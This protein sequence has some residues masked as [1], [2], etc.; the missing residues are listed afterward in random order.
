MTDDHRGGNFIF[1]DFPVGKS[2]TFRILTTCG[3]PRFR[4]R[5]LNENTFQDFDIAYAI[6]NNLPQSEDISSWE[7]DKNPDYRGSEISRRNISNQYE[8]VQ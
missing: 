5:I 3:Y 6:I 1:D 7:F 8:I 4:Y 2:C